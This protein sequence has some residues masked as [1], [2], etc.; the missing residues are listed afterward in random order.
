[1]SE[2]I[3]LTIH[4]TSSSTKELVS[5]ARKE[6]TVSDARD[7]QL[8]LRKPNVLAHF[9]LVKMLGDAAR[10]ATYLQLV[11]PLTYLAEIDGD[12]VMPP[13]TQRELDALI[14]RLDD[15][16]VMA[17]MDAIQ[18]HFGTPSAETLEGDLKNS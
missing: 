4:E 9:H 11:S 12:P 18:M 13:N 3:K 1:M 16:G 7:R 6:V 14:Q 8:K 15:E 17:I 10:N 2:A 5:K